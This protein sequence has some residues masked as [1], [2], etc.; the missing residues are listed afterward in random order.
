[1]ADEGNLPGVKRR[2]DARTRW[3]CA[4][5]AV[6][7]R[8]DGLFEVTAGSV[9]IG[10][11]TRDEPARRD[12]LLIALADNPEV[13]IG[14]LAWAFRISTK[15]LRQIRKF[16]GEHGRNALFSRKGGRRPLDARI[17]KR[18]R[19]LFDQGLDIDEAYAKVR[20]S[21]SRASVG[22]VHKRWAAERDGQARK[23]AREPR[24]Q[25][26]FPDT[27][28]SDRPV[29][30]RRKKR[31]PRDRRA[32]AEPAIVVGPVPRQPSVE[33][34]V[35]LGGTHVQHLGAWL[36]LGELHRAGLYDSAERFRC[37]ML[38]PEELRTVLDASA[39]ALTLGERC[40]EGV[41]RL[42][43]PSAP[44]LLR[45]HRRPSATGHASGCTPSRR[46]APCSCTWT[47]HGVS[48]CR[49]PR[50]MRLGSRCTS[51]TTCARTRASTSS[52]KAGG[53]RPSASFRAVPT[54]TSTTPQVAP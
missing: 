3:F 52:A 47:R 2:G 39:I 8:H 23:A 7:R 19:A 34:A 50:R 28:S 44:T 24:Q 14:D 42:A 26:L 17:K 40:V 13:R 20:R 9:L 18:V 30:V 46:E 29:S 48:R 51:T 49:W 25:E 36:M 31:A 16:V 43:T 6:H 41:R 33:D 5:G 11:F 27:A 22:R 1:M 4:D 15:R 45:N 53:C 37:D 32:P 21:T 38:A 54:T 10:T 12:V 35:E